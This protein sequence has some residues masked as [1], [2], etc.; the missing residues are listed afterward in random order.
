MSD[1]SS[2]STNSNIYG[3]IASGSKLNSAADGA[4]ELSILEEEKTTSTGLEVGA[5]NMASGI[6]LSNIEDGALASIQDYLQR[7]RELALQASNDLYSDT[8]KAAIQAEIDE[9]KQGISDVASQT[10]YNT[11]NLLDGSN[12]TLQMATDS[13]GNSTSVSGYDTTLEALGISD[14]DVT[15]EFDISKI[16]SALEAVTSTRSAIGAKTNALEYGINYNTSA[17]LASESSQSNLEDLDIA[18][19]VSEKKKQEVL[20]MYQLMMQKRKQD[21]EQSQYTRLFQS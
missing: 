13:N 6:D 17:Q 9:L 16:D 14:F 8:D 20:N 21:D 18:E 12:G 19:A 10:T 4:A 3:Q 15:G 11:L 1:I 5:D 2:V 7:I